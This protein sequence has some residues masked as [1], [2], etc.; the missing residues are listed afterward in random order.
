MEMSCVV[1]VGLII[2]LGV[3][4]AGIDLCDGNM[5]LQICF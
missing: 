4:W 2:Q 5:V 3:S 1:G